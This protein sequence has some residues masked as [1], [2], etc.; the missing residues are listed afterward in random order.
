MG[1]RTLGK[2]LNRIIKDLNAAAINAVRLL[3]YAEAESLARRSIWE[4]NR[5]QLDK[6]LA[7]YAKAEEVCARGFGSVVAAFVAYMERCGDS[8]DVV[9]ASIEMERNERDTPDGRHS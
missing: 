5:A 6:V 3:R 8:T 7:D 9:I 4:E 1:H 2:G